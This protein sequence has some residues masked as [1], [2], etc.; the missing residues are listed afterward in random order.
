MHKWITTGLLLALLLA[1]MADP[2]MA[3]EGCNGGGPQYKGFPLLQPT[4]YFA[5]QFDKMAPSP[6]IDWEGQPATWI[7][8]AYEKGWVVKTSPQD[9]QPGALVMGFT[10]TQN[11]WL[12]IVREVN[13]GEIK[14]DTLDAHGQLLHNTSTAEKMKSDY[15]L[16]GYIWPQRVA[17]AK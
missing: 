14:F 3:C 1:V 8:A 13:P 5:K 9:A 11:I 7:A 6:G 16:L 17:A 12:G 15:N 2:G 10:A 4:G